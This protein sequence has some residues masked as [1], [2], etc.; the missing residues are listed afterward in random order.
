MHSN[1]PIVV[2]L[3]EAVWDIFGTER[4][5][6][7]ATANVAYHAAQHGARGVVA[8][9]LGTDEAGR[10]LYDYFVSKGLDTSAIQWDADHETGRVTVDMRDPGHPTYVIHEEV[11]WDHLEPTVAL[12]QLADRADAVCF[13]SLAQRSPVARQAIQEFI[14]RTQGL[15]VFDVNLR[16]DWYDRDSLEHSLTHCRVAK[17]NID[18]LSTVAAELGLA[19]QSERAFARNLQARF[20]VETVIV[21]RAERGCF[22]ARHEEIVDLPGESI[23]LVDAVGAGDAFSAAFIMLSLEGQPLEKTARFANRAGGIV[24][25]RSGAMPDVA[26]DYRQLRAELGL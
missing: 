18:E 16:Q 26:Q 20:P 24:A 3:G 25:S 4:K 5:P 7:G 13:G 21:T 14:Q 11:A 23:Q 1:L 19:S 2:G 6:G 15:V 8:T 12:L 10:A 17:L 9:R 22:V